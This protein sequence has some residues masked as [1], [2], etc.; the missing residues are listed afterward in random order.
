MSIAFVILRSDDKFPTAD[1]I[2]KLN[3]NKNVAFWPDMEF[4]LSNKADDSD[5]SSSNENNK[6]FANT[7]R[8]KIRREVDRNELDI[9]GSKDL[10]I[11]AKDEQLQV[12]MLFFEN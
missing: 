3:P 10:L 11:I 4:F 8:L 5:A 12:I 6:S 7:L 9:D 2:G 1:T